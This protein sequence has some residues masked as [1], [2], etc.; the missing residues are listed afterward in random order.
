MLHDKEQL[1]GIYFKMYRN[2]QNKKKVFLKQY[3]LKTI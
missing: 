2:V 3:M 1:F